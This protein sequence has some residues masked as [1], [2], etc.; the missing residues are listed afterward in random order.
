M[1]LAR[2]GK[3]NGCPKMEERERKERVPFP[4]LSRS[5]FLPFLA[6][7][8]SSARQGNDQDQSRL[9]SQRQLMTARGLEELIKREKEQVYLAM[10]RCIVRP[11]TIN[12]A[13]HPESQGLTERKKEGI[14]EGVWSK[15]RIF[16]MRER[17]EEI[18]KRVQLEF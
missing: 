8:I 17:E 12:S 5:H 2:N 4:F 1:I 3:K 13:I 7:H 6:W 9:E 11:K 18:L 15:E 10:I 16:F 14:D